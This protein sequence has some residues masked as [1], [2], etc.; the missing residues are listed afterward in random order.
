MKDAKDIAVRAIKTFFQAGVAVW[1]ANGQRF[2]KAAITAALA[3]GISA[4]WNFVIKT[5]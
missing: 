5:A 4:V 1:V 2:D 3:A